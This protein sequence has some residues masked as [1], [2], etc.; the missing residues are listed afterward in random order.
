MN[1]FA[2]LAERLYAA[3]WEARRR[4]SA[5][6]RARPERLAA[7]VVSVGNLTVGGAGKT[8]CVLHLAERAAARAVRTA[9]VCRRYRPGPQGEG[10]EERMYRRAVPGIA[11]F[12]GTSKRALAREAVAAGAQLVLVD[13][14]FSHWPLARD[15]DLVL[16]DRT[17]LF[18]GGQL[19][20]AGRLREPLRALQRATAVIV[21]R[22]APDDDPGLLVESVRRHAPGARF[23]CARHR[24]TAVVDLAGRRCGA[25]GPARVLTATGNAAAVARSVQEAGFGPV[26]LSA[27]RDHH[28]WSADEA[29]REVAAA[30]EGTL[31]LTRKDAVRWPLAPGEGRVAVLDVAWEWVSGGDAIERHVFGEE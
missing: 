8:T 18:G 24:A 20:P 3:G 31:V 16:L 15:V 10:D 5:S 17:D 28:W 6:G 21:T 1:A 9:I 26:T 7:R 4:W 30:G 27:W 12:A 23:G 14:G 19:L 11:C 25:H 2:G 13:D 22:L 29:R